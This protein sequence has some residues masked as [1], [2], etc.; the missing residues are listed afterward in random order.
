MVLFIGTFLMIDQFDVP[1]FTSLTY[2]ARYFENLNANPYLPQMSFAAVSPL[3]LHL[4]LLFAV[5]AARAVFRTNLP[6]RAP[7]AWIPA[8]AFAGWLGL[9]FIAGSG[10]GGDVTAAL[11]EL[12]GLGYLLIM[13]AF[14]PQVIRTEKQI[15]AVVWV[16]IAAIAFKAFEGSLRFIGEG[17][18]LAG[19]DAMLTHEDPIFII[20]LWFLLLGMLVFGARSPQRTTILLLMPVLLLGFYAA[21]RRAA[22]A[23]LGISLIA[24]AVLVPPERLKRLLRRSIPVLAVLA[25]YTVVFWGRSTPLAAPL[26]QI[27]SGF[28]EDQQELGER[29]Y[30]SNM[31]R[32]LENFNLAYTIRSY[33]LVGIGFGTKYFQPLEL[34]KINYALRDY[35]AHNN[36]LWLLVKVGAVGFV[37]FWLFVNVFGAVAARVTKQLHNPFLQ[38]VG[39]MIV[40]AVVNQLVAAYFDLHLVRYRTMLYMG[41][42]MGLLPAL[43]GKIAP[44]AQPASAERE[45]GA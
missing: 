18:S 17:F 2:K 8:A 4:G 21:N 38:A 15:R 43:A 40:I 12:R 23:S 34:V 32:K 33:P 1:E 9:G 30:Y 5:W 16:C 41:T 45:V 27:R 24:F 39:G 19:H 11:W 29:N 31:Y 22:F 37:L 25:V 13:Y 42:L 35:M 20:T 28:V 3:D 7:S 14:V 6:G 10:R 36:I 44:E 26:N